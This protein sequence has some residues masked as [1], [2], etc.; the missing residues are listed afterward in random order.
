VQYFGVPRR[1]H[2]R[3]DGQARKYRLDPGGFA[4]RGPSKP[5]PSQ[6]HRYA[7]L[8]RRSVVWW[9]IPGTILLIGVLV[10]VKMLI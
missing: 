3:G 10:V 9:F 5:A 6:S 7:P 4:Y 8:P 2:R 1:G